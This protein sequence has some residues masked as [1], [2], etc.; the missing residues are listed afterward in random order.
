[1][2]AAAFPAWQCRRGPEQAGRT[3]PKTTR[4]D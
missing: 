4:E 1:L 2:A 3:L